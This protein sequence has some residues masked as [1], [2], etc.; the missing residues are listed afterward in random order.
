M[1]LIL[2]NYET[3]IKPIKSRIMVLAMSFWEQLQYEIAGS[4]HESSIQ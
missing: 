1:W 3:K 4:Y 2:F